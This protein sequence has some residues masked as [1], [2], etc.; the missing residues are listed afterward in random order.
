METT[1]GLRGTI[2]P[3]GA[4]G[5]FIESFT[6]GPFQISVNNGVIEI[7][8]EDESLVDVAREAVRLYVDAS[9]FVRH[10]LLTVDLNQSWRKKTPVSNQVTISA[11]VTLNVTD[12]LQIT[13]TSMDET[14]KS[15]IVVAFDSRSLTNQN[16]LVQKAQ[17]AP[18]LASA[19]QYLNEEVV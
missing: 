5:N 1:F 10:R 9:R 17:K 19:L 12:E 16:D 4:L 11:S 15:L 8:F 6:D 18:P 3:N 13:V 2:M 7:G 14:G